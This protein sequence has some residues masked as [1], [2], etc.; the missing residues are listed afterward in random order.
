MI[1]FTSA[2]S[3]GVENAFVA[4]DMPFMTSQIKNP[5]Q[6]KMVGNQLNQGLMQLKLKDA[7][8]LFLKILSI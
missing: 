4:A 7:M 1:I 2:I 5:K 3:L 8:I 6:L